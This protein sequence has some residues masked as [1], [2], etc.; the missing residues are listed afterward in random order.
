MF[1]YYKSRLIVSDI[2]IV[3]AETNVNFLSKIQSFCHRRSWCLVELIV[4]L[5]C[6]L[7]LLEKAIICLH[8]LVILHKSFTFAPT[9]TTVSVYMKFPGFQI[10]I[11]ICT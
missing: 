1:L 5:V 2:W 10:C 6:F 11:R 4:R 8:L 3:T 7:Q 9:Y